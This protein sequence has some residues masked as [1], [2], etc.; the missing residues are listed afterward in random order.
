ML[1]NQPA[2]RVGGL[3]ANL[4]TFILDYAARQKVGG[5]HLTFG[6]MNQLPVLPPSSYGQPC[7]WSTQESV[8]AWVLR[9][10]LELTYTACDLRLFAE[11]CGYQGE[12]FRW[13]EDRR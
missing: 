7:P 1:P 5:T 11:D 9:R 6:L 10:V 8:S 2:D 13:D 3:S 12:P 4:A